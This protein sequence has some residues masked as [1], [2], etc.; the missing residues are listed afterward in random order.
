MVRWYGVGTP[1]TRDQGAPG[2][3][4]SGAILRAVTLPA[5]A[6]ADPACH[7]EGAAIPA[8]PGDP[9]RPLVAR[10]A[11]FEDVSP[12]AWDA[13]A[14]RNPWA[15]PFA[16]WAFH[17]AWWDGYGASAHDETVLVADPV[18]EA[19]GESGLVAIVPLMHRHG[20]EPT[21]AARH[22]MLRRSADADLTRLAPTDKVVFFGD[23]ADHP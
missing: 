1:P 13:L 23:C 9:L 5:A 6:D 7:D 16:R 21:D 10:R 14:A 3:R 18:A 15:T 8:G 11:T 19:R 4:P 22:T 2:V 20:V 17:R 12:Q